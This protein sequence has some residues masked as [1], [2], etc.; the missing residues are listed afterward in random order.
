MLLAVL[1]PARCHSQETVRVSLASEQA[2]LAQRPTASSNYYNLLLGPVYLRFQGAMGVELNDNANYSHTAPDA[3]IAL[4]PNLN[5]KALWP[6]SP[7]N[8]LT[9]STG[10][11]YVDYLRDS[12]L[13]HVNIASDSS[14]NFKLYT[15][16]FVFDLHDRFSAVDYASQDPSVSA[17]VERLENDP[18]VNADWDLNKL[19][20]SLGLDYD[21]F[22]SLNSAYAYSDSTSELLHSRAAFLVH[23]TDRLGLE[24]GGG[25]TTYDQNLLDNCAHFSFG[26]FYD[27][28]LTPYLRV[29]AEMGFAAYD[30][31]HNGAVTNVNNFQGYYADITFSQRLNP[32]WTQKLSFGRE[33]QLD[34]TANFSDNY[35]IRYGAVW[36]MSQNLS[37]TFGLAFQHGSTSGAVAEDETYNSFG[38]NLG[39]SWRLSPKMVGSLNYSFVEKNSDVSALAY[40]QNKVLLDFTYDF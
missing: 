22:T 28:R 6:V 8:T 1:I 34:I 7:Q 31:A 21:T 13:S 40:T 29:E 11:G 18:G 15:G 33:I 9:L 32:W 14:L 30:F 27:G 36:R 17:S 12:F 39:L 16:D 5:L 37:S 19:I 35:Y 10:I 25:L 24:A 2:A 23:A 3:D 26:P 4:L 20:L 38:P